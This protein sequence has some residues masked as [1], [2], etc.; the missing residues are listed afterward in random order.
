VNL[1][2]SRAL[3]SGVHG[4]A[5]LPGYLVLA[6][7]A[8]ACHAPAPDQRIRP[9]YDAESGKLKVLKYDE[10]GDGKVDAVSYMDGARV[11]RIEIDKNQDGKIERW[12]YYGADQ[13][14]AKVGF[15][16]ADD[17]KEDAWSYAA[18]DGSIAKIEISTR[19][20]G[21][22]SRT[23]HYEHE[24][25]VAA[26]E[27]TDGDGASDKW[28]TFAGG[29]LTSVAYDSTRRGSPDRRLLYGSDGSLR[30]EVDPDGD[31]AFAPARP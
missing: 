9:E 5:R 13:K 18:P 20:D 25:L 12:E 15:S 19:R 2:F 4:A 28:E 6:A 31:G 24:M 22:I 11:L 1:L 23:E 29:R 8:A 14:L 10:N 7:I 27:D 30:I 26:E 21:K 16:R 3:R 17:G